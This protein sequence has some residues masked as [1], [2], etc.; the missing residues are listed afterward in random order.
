VCAQT[1]V[2]ITLRVTKNM[3]V[4]NGRG[5]TCKTDLVAPATATTGES[6]RPAMP[7]AN[8]PKA[9]AMEPDLMPAAVCR[10]RIQNGPKKT[11]KHDDRL[12]LE[13]ELHARKECGGLWVAR[14]PLSRHP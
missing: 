3:R 6:A 8:P 1:F 2:G 9:L 7:E 11:Q 5:R 4:G 14:P 10:I 13:V 12:N